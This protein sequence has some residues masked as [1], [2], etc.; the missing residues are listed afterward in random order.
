MGRMGWVLFRE[1]KRLVGNVFKE[2]SLRKVKEWEDWE[3]W[4]G[5]CEGTHGISADV[6]PLMIH[7]GVKEIKNHNIDVYTPKYTSG[8]V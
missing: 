7:N 8:V 2:G 6:R 3:E 4:G 1:D 5:V